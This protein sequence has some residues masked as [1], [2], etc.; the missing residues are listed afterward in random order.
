MGE[1]PFEVVR[2]SGGSVCLSHTESVLSWNYLQP[3]VVDFVS[4]LRDLGNPMVA[5]PVATDS[6]V[7]QN[8]VLP[9]DLVVSLSKSSSLRERQARVQSCW[10]AMG[11]RHSVSVFFW[12]EV[13]ESTA[14]VDSTVL[15]QSADVTGQSCFVS[16]RV[17]G[18]PNNVKEEIS[19]S[20]GAATHDF[21]GCVEVHDVFGERHIGVAVLCTIPLQGLQ[22]FQRTLKLNLN[23][24]QLVF[25]SMHL[26]VLPAR[27]SPKQVEKWHSQKTIFLEA[28]HGDIIRS[29]RRFESKWRKFF[30]KYLIKGLR[31]RGRWIRLKRVYGE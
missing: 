24:R 16:F 22:T 7:Q 8:S 5:C 23:A 6:F 10:C 29:S 19:A 11:W 17:E 28:S 26:E 1:H 30:Q 13:Y 9:G 18:I 3:K 4:V 20:I 2:Q 27:V 15:E 14:D 31:A 12:P 25:A 21:Y